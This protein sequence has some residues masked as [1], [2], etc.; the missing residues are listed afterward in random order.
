MAPQAAG[1]SLV[2]RAFAFAARVS[3]KKHRSDWEQWTVDI[4][5]LR[6]ETA[7]VMKE[8]AGGHAS[9]CAVCVH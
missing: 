5:S 1:N 6:R 9:V 4:S 2:P 8:T 3:A 7:I